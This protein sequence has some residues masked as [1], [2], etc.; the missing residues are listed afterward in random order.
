M[1]MI[2]TLRELIGIPPAGLEF[3]EYIVS[4]IFLG[5][6]CFGLLYIIRL[7]ISFIKP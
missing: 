7:L 4:V 6:M 5:A 2:D 3:L 1:F